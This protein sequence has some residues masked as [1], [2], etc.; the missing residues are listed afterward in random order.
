MDS[1][2]DLSGNYNGSNIALY[3]SGRNCKKFLPFLFIHILL[4]SELFR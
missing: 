4:S 1:N 2:S 3:K